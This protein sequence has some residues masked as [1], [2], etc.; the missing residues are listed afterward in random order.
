M[1][2]LLTIIAM[3]LITLAPA[4]DLQ[5]FTTT[6]LDQFQV[7]VEYDM[8][9]YDVPMPDLYQ[10]AYQAPMPYLQQP[11]YT[12]ELAQ[13]PGYNTWGPYYVPPFDY[14]YYQPPP[15]YQQYM[16]PVYYPQPQHS[17]SFYLI[18]NA[19]LNDCTD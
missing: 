2:T 13:P 14:G 8:Q 9:A 6:A 10:P 19:L 17:E 11:T 4:Q 7:Y 12:I 3:L 18:L 16:H 5:E 15:R 1:K